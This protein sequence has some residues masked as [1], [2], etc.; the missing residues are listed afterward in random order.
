MNSI[1][2]AVITEIH[3]A[4]QAKYPGILVYSD[5]TAYSPEFPCVSVYEADN[6]SAT[7]TID[8]SG[9]E[10]FSDTMYQVDVYSNLEQG[11]KA[12]CKSII[13]IIDDKLVSLG[14]VRTTK[15]P[16]PNLND[17]N[18]YRLTARYSARVGKDN[19]IYRR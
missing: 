14:L 12:Q 4:L 7:D 1:E 15:L 18:I 19:T 8:S 3:T 11:R 2:N 13:G 9:R 6:A 17:S 10:K 5:A 16:A